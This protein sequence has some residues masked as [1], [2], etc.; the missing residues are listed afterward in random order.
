[1]ASVRLVE[2]L[3]ELAR[4]EEQ[5]EAISAEME[6]Y[7]TSWEHL[8]DQH[9]LLYAEY[10]RRRK[11]W[12]AEEASLQER[13]RA[14][15]SAQMVATERAETAQRLIHALDGRSGA[16]DD[17]GVGRKNILAQQ[18]G[19]KAVGQVDIEQREVERQ[20]LDHASRLV[21]RADGGH[22]GVTL[23]QRGRHLF[24]QERLILDHQHA[25]TL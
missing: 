13:A 23:L 3:A 8:Q 15:E 4:R 16:D 2:A 7:R 21:E 19:A 11:E 18:V 5:L 17:G 9:R 24:A 25:G 20:R 22:I 10:V 6:A 14:A 1:M 12:K